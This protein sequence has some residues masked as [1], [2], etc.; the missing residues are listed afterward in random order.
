[1]QLYHAGVCCICVLHRL[2]YCRFT[3]S[4]TFGGMIPRYKM[5]SRTAVPWRGD[6]LNHSRF[7]SESAEELHY[8]R[9]SPFLKVKTRNRGTRRRISGYDMFECSQEMRCGH[10][11]HHD[12][13]TICNRLLVTK[14]IAWYK[15]TARHMRPCPNCGNQKY[16]LTASSDSGIQEL[17][18]KARLYV[19]NVDGAWYCDKNGL[20]RQWS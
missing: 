12:Q 16:A 20:L 7:R 19:G 4:C 13:M 6:L 18:S 8:L 3:Y 14:V 1:M 10:C 17:L 11:D 15:Q 5:C 2:G 9:S